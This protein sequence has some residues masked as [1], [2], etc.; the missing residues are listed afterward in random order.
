M[1]MGEGQQQH[2]NDNDG[3]WDD[4]NDGQEQWDNGDR[5]NL[6]LANLISLFML[7]NMLL[8]NIHVCSLINVQ[9]LYKKVTAPK[10]VNSYLNDAL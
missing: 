9:I 2:N 10:V 1:P 6:R 7:H 4:G 8:L 5:D 3:D